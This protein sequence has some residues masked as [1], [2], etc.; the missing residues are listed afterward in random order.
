MKLLSNVVCPT[1]KQETAII[2]TVQ[3]T[4]YLIVCCSQCGFR[5]A[6]HQNYVAKILFDSSKVKCI[7]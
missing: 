4:E 1:C 6:Y 2:E 5:D 7:V 3:R